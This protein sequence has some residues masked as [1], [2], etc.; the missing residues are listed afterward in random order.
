M[1]I[2]ELGAVALVEDEGDAAVLQGFELLLVGG[3]AV[4]R[5][6]LVALA[7]LI[8]GEAQLLDGGDDDFV[9]VVLRKQTAHEGGGVGIFL[10]AA[11]LEAVELLARLAIEVF[12]IHDKEAFLDVGIVL[13]QGGGLEG[14]E[15]LAAAGGVPDEAVATVIVNAF[16]QMLHRI[17]LIRAHHEQLLLT[18]DEHHVAADGLAQGAFHQEGRG[19]VVEVGDLLVRFIGELVDRQKALLGVKGKVAGVVVGEV[20]GVVSIA[21]DEELE[22]AEK[23]LGVAVACIVFVF[24]DLFH[25]P[26]RLY[27]E[28]LQLNLHA[29]HAIDQD[30]HIVTVVAVIRVDAELVNDLEGVFAPVLDVDQGV[31][32]GRAVI[33]GEGI[34][35]A[36]DF[37]GG[38][39][40]GR[41]DLVKQSGKLGIGQMH[42]VKRLELFAEVLL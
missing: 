4:L 30:E 8:Q 35:L 28:S 41:D 34:E 11:F 33:A 3:L 16:H 38:E 1:V 12:A 15:R 18:G 27:A 6:L 10:D 31:V 25:G 5:A 29:G 22:E 32:Q 40:I 14:R 13:Q 20:V 9:R 17:D 19:E 26:A 21:N 7:V 37:G 2:A 23:G 42:S 24:D 39:D 36:K